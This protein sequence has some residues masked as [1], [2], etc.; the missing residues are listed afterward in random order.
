MQIKRTFNRAVIAAG[1]FVFIAVISVNAQQDKLPWPQFRGPNGSGIAKCDDIP[2]NFGPDKNIQWKIAVSPG[3]SCPVV[4]GDRIFLTAYDEGDENWLF[5]L[6]IDSNTGGL[7]WQKELKAESDVRFHSMNGPASCTPVVDEKHVYVY[8]GTY[9]LTCYDHDGKLVWEKKLETPKNKYGMAVSPILHGEKLIMVLDDDGSKS[10]MIAFNKNTGQEIWSVPRV[11]FRS[12]W[13][14]PMIWEHE[15]TTELVVLGSRRLTSYNPEDGREIWW[16]SGFSVETVGVPVVGGGL[17]FAGTSALGG[18]GDD[19]PD[20]ELTWDITIRD[21]DKN[22]D[23]RIQRDEMVD[24]FT[25]PLRPELSKDNPGY[26]LPISNM[27][28]LM[29]YLDKDNDKIIDKHDWVTT[30]GSAVA[31]NRPVLV[32]VKP[33]ANQDAGKSHIAWEIN[34]GVP[35]TSSPLYYRDRIYLLRDG[36]QLTCLDAS[37][38]KEIY[39]EKLG[40]SGQYI[41]SPVACGDKIVTASRNGVVCVIKIDDKLDILAKNKFKE[42]IMATPAIADNK[43]YLRTIEHLYAIGK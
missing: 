17:L 28:Y 40:A 14:T 7:L 23:D 15:K 18:R 10:R 33:G 27:D 39:R 41:A 4:T 8:F 1:F 11:L 9:G 6:A 5:I 24:G 19:Q 20:A 12:G 29:R 26:G 43:I 13:A 35:E 21:F 34:R 36:G 30:L 25:V 2:V 22:K 31:T 42:K 38:G 37:D 16:I 3:H 32:A